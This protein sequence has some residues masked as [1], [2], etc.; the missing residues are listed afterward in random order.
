MFHE[1]E[2]NLKFQL[3]FVRLTIREAAE[4][5]GMPLN[6]LFSKLNGASSLTDGERK[7]LENL[8]VQRHEARK[9]IPQRRTFK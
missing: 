2:T 3:K 4:A 1:V 9:L 6:T 8:I 7:A 5:L